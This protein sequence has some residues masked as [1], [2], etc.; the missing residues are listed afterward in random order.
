MARY[1][2]PAIFKKD[3]KQYTVH[4][5]D[6]EGCYTQGESLEDAFEMAE[7]VLCLTLYN[8]EERQ[9]NAPP[10]SEMEKIET[11]SGEFVSLI[12]CDTLS[13]RQYYDNRAVKKT[14]TI[15]AWMNTMA[16]RKGLNFSA[17]LQA[18]LKAELCADGLR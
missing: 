11:N 3:G 10:A 18:A 7:D 14:L 12:P 5:P 2:Y 9:E 13:Y 4:F 6:L 15:P 17:V 8:M 16:E 1:L